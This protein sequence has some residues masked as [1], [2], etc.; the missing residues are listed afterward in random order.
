MIDVKTLKFN[1]IYLL[2]K[3]F[4]Y[5]FVEASDITPN[6][7]FDGGVFT[8]SLDIFGKLPKRLAGVYP[9]THK[10]VVW[11]EDDR[12]ITVELISGNIACKRNIRTLYL[13]NRIKSP[14]NT[15]NGDS[16]DVLVAFDEFCISLSQIIV[17]YRLSNP[18]FSCSNVS[19]L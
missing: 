7:N 3:K 4:K 10:W 1:I 12:D 14:W 9:N 2:S 8:I 5:S 11:Y 19:L 15:V 18:K 16:D 6:M 13:K 17:Q